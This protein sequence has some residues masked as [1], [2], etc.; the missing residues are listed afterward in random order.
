[1]ISRYFVIALALV[2]AVVRARDHA[3]VETIGLGALAAGLTCLRFAETRQMPALKK[4]A[5]ALFAITL[6][7]MG[8]VFQR[9]YLR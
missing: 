3:W 9:D 2:A 1:M 6:V 4:L 8:I 5:W 7:A